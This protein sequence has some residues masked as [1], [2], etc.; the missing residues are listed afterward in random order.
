MLKVNDKWQFLCAIVY[1]V[2]A[3]AAALAESDNGLVERRIEEGKKLAFDRQKGNC[4]ACHQIDDGALAGNVA[5]ALAD[6]AVRYSD[7]ALLRA[8]IWDATQINPKTSM[9]PFGR[10]RILTDDEI[11]LITDYLYSL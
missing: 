8:R 1:V 5:P 7:R 4:L 9:P 6:M 2:F 10:H 11:D 3:S